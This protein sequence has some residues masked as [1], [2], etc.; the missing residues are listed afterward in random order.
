MVMFY[1]ELAWNRKQFL[2]WTVILT[3]SSVLML[4]M[5]PS[6]AEQADKYTELLKNSPK[7]MISGLGAGNMDFAKVLDFFAYII[8]YII[9]FAA[10]YAMLLGAG[11]LSTEEDEQTI[12]FLLAKPVTRSGIVTAKYA[13]AL[14]YLL[15]LNVVLTLAN[16]IAIEAFKGK[17]T[18]SLKAF[19]M[20]ALGAFLVQWTFASIGFFLSVFVVRSKSLTPISLGVVLGTYFISIASVVSAKLE[21]LKYVTPFQY[22]NPANIIKNEGLNGVYVSIMVGFIAIMTVGTYWAYQRKDIKG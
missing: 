6:I 8:P 10:I 14:V 9:L 4:A 13:A 22:V 1:R 2:I 5:F 11:M 7:A 12:D 17:S 18:Y 16:Y 20:I 15:L 3:L 21:N 19:L